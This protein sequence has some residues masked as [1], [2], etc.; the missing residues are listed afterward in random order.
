M[1]KVLRKNNLVA[2]ILVLVVVC[3]G[4]VFAGDVIIKEGDMDVGDVNSAGDGEFAGNL[5]VGT[6]SS[7]NHLYLESNGQPTE[8]IRGG[9][10]A[11][12]ACYGQYRR[13]TYINAG[14]RFVWDAS[15]QASAFDAGVAWVD[16]DD[17]DAHFEGDLSVIGDITTV[18]GTVYG[19]YVDALFLGLRDSSTAKYLRF[20]SNST[21][22]LTAN[23]ILTFDVANAARTITFS[24][25]PTLADWFDQSVKRTDS[26][27]FN[28]VTA[29]LISTDIKLDLD[30]NGGT[31][32]FKL[33]AGQEA[34]IWYDGTNLHIDARLF[35]SG[36]VIIDNLPT[37]DPDVTGG[38]W[39]DDNHF[40][41]VSSP[42]P[43]YKK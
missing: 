25:N 12:D 14:H 34:G 38:L 42:I 6:S 43:P 17:G 40:L 19:N 33:G 39:V 32:T 27:T 18:G 10:I 29:K 30:G 4:I 31:G 11:W 2:G 16:F 28:T 1:K 24:G 15:A 36:T 13:Y 20:F 22:D 7:Q 8:F 23:R 26:P 9:S 3:L 21:P 35:G 5:T 37:A 41:K